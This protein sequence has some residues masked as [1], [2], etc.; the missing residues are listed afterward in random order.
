MHE[1]RLVQTGAGLC[2][3]MSPCVP[4]PAKKI[5]TDA[6]PPEQAATKTEDELCKSRPWYA[7]RAPALLQ[8]ELGGACLHASS[9]PFLGQWGSRGPGTD[10]PAEKLSPQRLNSP[11]L[12]GPPQP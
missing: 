12:A 6:R 11:A 4:C 10:S 5:S 9:Q 1:P 7:I 2:T 8:A 3:S